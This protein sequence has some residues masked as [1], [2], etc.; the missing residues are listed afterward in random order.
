MKKWVWAVVSLKHGLAL[1]LRHLRNAR[2]RKRPSGAQDPHYLTQPDGRVT[3]RYP[4]EKI[5]APDV[6]RY[7]LFLEIDDCI[8]CDQCARICPVA[9]ITIEKIKS[10]TV[11]GAASDGTKKRFYL[12]VFDIDL[13]KCC[14]CGL[15]TVVCPTE[16][17]I[18]TDE[19]EYGAYDRSLF[20]DRWSKMTPQEREQRQAEL[21]RFEAQKQ[22]ALSKARSAE[23]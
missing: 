15:C 16:C 19:Y 23:G 21:A 22:V 1:T 11:I 17:L 20:T 13:A 6:G 10:P 14:F 8:G 12:P 2:R 7:K 5:P 18:M 3:I 9:C 4:Q